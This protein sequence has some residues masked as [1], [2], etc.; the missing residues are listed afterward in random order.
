M[1]QSERLTIEFD[2]EKTAERKS[3]KQIQMFE[4]P[5]DKNKN[6]LWR[7]EIRFIVYWKLWF[8]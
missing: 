4:L 6:E 7:I 3:A 2:G 1:I 8:D 5:N